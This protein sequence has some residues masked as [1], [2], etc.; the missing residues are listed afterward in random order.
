[1]VRLAIILIILCVLFRMAIG[2]WP[3]QMLKPAP[4]RSQ[5]LFKARKL[6]GVEERATRADIL[7]AHKR[8][9]A[10]VHPDRGG[11]SAAVHEANDARDLLLSELPDRGAPL[12]DESF[13]DDD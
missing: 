6:L 2:Q 7:A 4:T 9:I 10:M 5:A 13:E 12:R 1:M 11:S 3:W 8:L